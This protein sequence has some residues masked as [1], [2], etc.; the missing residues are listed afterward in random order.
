MEIKQ[1]SEP[2]N[3]ELVRSIFAAWDRG[4]F[5]S[6]GWAHPEIEFVIADGPAPGSWKGLAGMAKGW[7]EFLSA[8]EEWR[9]EAE[10]YRDLDGERVLVL[11]RMSGRG[12][13][14]GVEAEQMRAKAAKVFHVRGGKVTRFVTYW[15]RE[16][17]LADLGLPSEAAASDS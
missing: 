16:R 13:A 10:G 3:V 11:V 12:K 17:A 15:D 4:D 8:W 6:A 1:S 9:E 5:S 2:G 14:S 7:G